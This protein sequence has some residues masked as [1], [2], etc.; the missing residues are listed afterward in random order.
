MQNRTDHPGVRRDL[1][2][3]HVAHGTSS[4][5][6]PDG[7]LPV[8]W[9]TIGDDVAEAT[10]L[11]IGHP[12]SLHQLTLGPPSQA[13]AALR[14]LARDIEGRPGWTAEAADLALDDDP[15]DGPR[16]SQGAGA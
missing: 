8:Q 15:P 11:S 16:G 10:Y 2:A 3:P 1:P 12:G 13:V 7:P 14:S 4:L 9:T 5:P 6:S